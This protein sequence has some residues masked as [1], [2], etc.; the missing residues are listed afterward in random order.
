MARPRQVSDAAILEA[1]AA[2]F[3]EDPNVP[4]SEIARRVGLSQAA[5]FKRFGTKMRLMLAAMGVQDGPPWIELTEAGPDE[6]PIPDQLNQIGHA[7][8]DFFRDLMPRVVVLKAVGASFRELFGDDE[9]PPPIKGY[10]AVRDWFSRAIDQ[11]RIHAQDPQ[12]LALAFIA[13][14][15]ARAFWMQM[16]GPKHSQGLPEGPEYVDHIVDLFWN[17][18]A[19]PPEDS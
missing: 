17:G 13:M 5:L 18:I 6:R 8:D 9:V 10:Q 12:A 2:C 4:T 14:F 7:I 11:D 1:A 16:G 3:K 15:Q 19:P